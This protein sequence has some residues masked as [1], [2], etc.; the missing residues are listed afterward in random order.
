MY[1]YIYGHI[2]C[3]IHSALRHIEPKNFVNY[4]MYKTQSAETVEYTD[5]FSAEE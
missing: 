1:I 5:C 2:G 4:Y 3:P